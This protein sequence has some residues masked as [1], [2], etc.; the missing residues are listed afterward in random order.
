MYWAV[1]RHTRRRGYVMRA[2][3]VHASA[4]CAPPVVTHGVASGA[5]SNC[6]HLATVRDTRARAIVPVCRGALATL[7]NIKWSWHGPTRWIG[8]V[9]TKHAIPERSLVLQDMIAKTSGVV[10][11]AWP[12]AEGA[13]CDTPRSEHWCCKRGYAVPDLGSRRRKRLVPEKFSA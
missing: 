9:A 7:L 5:A 2:C 6:I 13:G 10:V 4:T 1:G 8:R 3:S 11:V 12:A